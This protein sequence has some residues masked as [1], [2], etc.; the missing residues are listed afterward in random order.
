MAARSR[1]LF[2]RHCE[3]T[4]RANA[5]PMT[6]SAKQSICRRRKFRLLRRSAPRKDGAQISNTPSRSRGAKRPSRESKLP[7]QRRGRR[8]C[9]ARAAPAIS[10]AKCTKEDAHEHT[11]SAEATSAFP[12]QWFCGLWRAPRRRIRLVTVIGRLAILPGPVRPA[13][14]S[15][16]LTPATGARTTRFCRTQPPAFAERGFAGLWRRSS[17]AR[18]IAHGTNPPCDFDLTPTLPRPPHPVPT[19]VTMANAP[20]LKDETA[21]LIVLICPMG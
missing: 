6:G 18:D 15:T 11:G 2:G 3:R 7:P 16:D 21:R 20:S 14:I 13:K 10:C 19:F 12:T 4:G 17:C 8:E 5:R 1:A 9:R